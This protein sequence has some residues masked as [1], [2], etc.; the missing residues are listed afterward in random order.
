MKS[1]SVVEMTQSRL[2]LWTSK[3]K[4]VAGNVALYINDHIMNMQCY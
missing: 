2:S 4:L 3:E 1:D